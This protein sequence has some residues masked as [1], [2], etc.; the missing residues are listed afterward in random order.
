MKEK[1][2]VAHFADALQAAKVT[3]TVH[4]KHLCKMEK[5]LGQCIDV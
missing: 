3:A 2:I 4:S 5:A 1:E